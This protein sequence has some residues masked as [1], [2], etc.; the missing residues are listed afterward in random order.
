MRLYAQLANLPRNLVSE[1]DL[2]VE[3]GSLKFTEGLVVLLEA[4]DWNVQPV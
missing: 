3:G 1:M 4:F 2:D